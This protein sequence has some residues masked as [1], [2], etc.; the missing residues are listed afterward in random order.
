MIYHAQMWNSSAIKE[1]LHPVL[2]RLPF[3]L[4][5][6]VKKEDCTFCSGHCWRKQMLPVFSA[7]DVE[8]MQ[9]LFGITLHCI[10]LR[11]GKIDTFVAAHE[12]V[13]DHLA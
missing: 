5:G 2:L 6:R 8:E 13:L 1:L 7:L 11:Y 3:F 4:H 10:I 9:Y 12:N